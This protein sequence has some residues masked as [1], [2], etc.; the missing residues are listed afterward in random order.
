M[1]LRD[2]PVEFVKNA[3]SCREIGMDRRAARIWAKAVA[4]AQRAIADHDN[5]FV[6]PQQAAEAKRLR[7]AIAEADERG[8]PAAEPVRRRRRVPIQAW[9]PAA[10]A[11]IPHP[12][13]TASRI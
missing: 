1:N 8:W 7:R 6:T 5:E 13:R 9:G 3:T 11:W 10:Q 12:K 4:M 2:L